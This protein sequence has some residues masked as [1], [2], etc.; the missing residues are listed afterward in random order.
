MLAS[1]SA[2]AAGA[3]AQGFTTGDTNIAPGTLLSLESGQALV[4]SASSKNVA[5]LVGVA[6]SKSL[7][8][9]SNSSKNVQVV[10]SGLTE[11]LVSNVNGDIK[12]GDRITASPFS[13]I[14]MKAS[15]PT[16]TV[17]IAEANLSAQHVIHEHLTDRDG[18][19]EAINVGSIPLQVN[20]AFYPENQT[21][22]IAALI[23]PFLQSVA[24]AI[25]GQQVSPLKI[26]TS[27]LILILGF[28][29]V[30]VILYASVR[31]S[32]SAIGRNPLA[33]VAVRKGLIDILI[34][35]AGILVITL[36]AIYLI[37]GL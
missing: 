1:G 14:G 12:T 30:G 7:V 15:A 10:V 8:E 17:G 2:S 27:A 21:N 4:E 5:N 18:K 23:P 36:V 13:G 35:A 3:I 37:I 19:S 29:I 33:N 31:S 16:E 34:M 28:T 9:L 11:A 24:N 6:S 26:L 22:G 20:V 32:I 25:S